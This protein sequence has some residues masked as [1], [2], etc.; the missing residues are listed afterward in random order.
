[1]TNDTTKNRRGILV[2]LNRQDGGLRIDLDDVANDQSSPRNWL[3]KEHVTN[4][5]FPVDAFESMEFDEKELANLGYYVLARL[6]AFLARN[7]D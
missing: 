3:Q 2:T 7:E 4:K 1:M 6:S 5:C